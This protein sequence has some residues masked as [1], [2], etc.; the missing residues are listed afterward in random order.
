MARARVDVSAAEEALADATAPHSQLEVDQAD[1]KVTNAKDAVRV[2]EEKLLDL[3]RPTEHQLAAAESAV[4]D[5]VLKISTIEDDIASLTSHDLREVDDLMFQ[6]RTAQVVPGERPPRP[7]ADGAG[8]GGQGRRRHRRR[9][10]RRGLTTGCL[11]KSGWVSSPRTSTA[12]CPPRTS[13][14]YGAPT[15]TRCSTRAR[16]TAVCFR[17]PWSMTPLRRGT[18]TPY[19]PSLISPLTTSGLSAR[20]LPRPPTS[21]ASQMK[22]RMLGRR[23]RMPGRRLRDLETPGGH[24]RLQ[25]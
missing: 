18:S 8:L 23:S 1:A 19:T 25:G 17:L 2:A 24:R 11:S 22:C 14:P 13:W 10:R 15:W 12:P 21:S 3:L 6:I 9:G 4:A 5:A 20:K 7:I 16:W